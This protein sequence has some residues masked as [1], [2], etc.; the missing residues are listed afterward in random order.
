MNE[1]P[2]P[3]GGPEDPRRH[4]PTTRLVEALTSPAGIAVGLGLAALVSYPHLVAGGESI[5]W[6]LHLDAAIYRG[7]VTGAQSGHLYEWSY[8]GNGVL[9]FTYPPFAAVLLSPLALLSDTQAQ[10]LMALVTPLTVAVA[11]WAMAHG[12]GL[13]GRAAVGL[14]PWAAAGALWLQPVW[15]TMDYG[16][17][18][19]ILLALVLVDVL[20]VPPRWRGL[21][22][23][24]A[25]ALKVTPAIVL[26][27]FLLRRDA[28]GAALMTGGALAATA[29]GAL[30]FPHDTWVY[31]TRAMWEPARTGDTV[32]GESQSLRGM[33]ERWTGWES[34]TPLWAV[35][36]AVL[37]VGAVVLARRYLARGEEVAAL[38]VVLVAGLVA[39][40][41]TWD[42]H[43]VWCLLV[44]ALL[45][46][47][48]LCGP[49]APAL[50]ALALTV[51]VFA[52]APHD[53]LPTHGGH[54]L[55]WPW[56]AQVMGAAF[57]LWAIGALAWGLW[58]TRPARRPT[59]PAVLTAGS[60]RS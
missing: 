17:V 48:V 38:A 53:W 49:T 37:G 50:L 23:G 4:R 52:T 39:S 45:V 56:W 24:V 6:A 55:E 47:E 11:G 22:C 41:V 31:A 30:A 26:L 27:W 58:A 33:L 18:N 46:R 1:A 44:V 34:V 20:V 54:E 12:A 15:R 28:R 43:W 51:G 16:Q 42:H 5:S 59:P 25:A 9:P 29:V 60:G 8:A 14:A 10:V 40:P 57:P 13:R 3:R 36:L 7:A 2:A 21:A 19:G 32:V 35:A